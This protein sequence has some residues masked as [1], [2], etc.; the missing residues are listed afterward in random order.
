VDWWNNTSSLAPT[1]KILTSCVKVVTYDC[2]KS[3]PCLSQKKK[4]SSPC[5]YN[6]MTMPNTKTEP[7]DLS[8]ALCLSN[9]SVKMARRTYIGTKRQVPQD[10][11]MLFPINCVIRH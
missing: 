2:P 10:K 6:S 11:K 4:K 1:K 5:L 9:V 8:L 3:S 7:V